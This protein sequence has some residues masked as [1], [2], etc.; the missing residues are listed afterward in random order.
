MLNKIAVTGEGI[1]DMGRCLQGNDCTGE[2][3]DIGPIS[4]LLLKLIARHLP[5]WNADLLEAQ[6]PENCLTLLY[7]A[8]LGEISKDR[9]LIRPNKG[10]IKQGFVEHA[11]RAEALAHYALSKRHEMAAY[12]H[13]TD[14]THTDPA[15]QRRKKLKEAIEYGF[16]VAGLGERGLTLLP[17]PKSE[18]WF[19]CA[20]KPNSY[21]HCDLL[22]ERLSGN[23][24]SPEH[25]PKK[26]LGDYLQNPSYNSQ[27]LNELVEQIDVDRI[28]MPS[29]N[30]LREQVKTA[31]TTFCGEC[32]D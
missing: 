22:E 15:P 1:T 23:D 12:F 7:H 19:I 8:H 27:D 29:F 2:N 13:D 16:R 24:C 14:G 3:L 9:S 28:D 6:S 25:A 21:Q 20:V 31:I 26:V 10:G 5:E 4:L 17:Q 30:E 11:Q 18:A 32:R